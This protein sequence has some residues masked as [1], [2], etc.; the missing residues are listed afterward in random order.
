MP[1]G[2]QTLDEL[3]WGEFGEEMQD[4]SNDEEYEEISCE[5]S[6]SPIQ[7]EKQ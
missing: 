2:R 7:E 6:N 5:A 1:K 4:A 3:N